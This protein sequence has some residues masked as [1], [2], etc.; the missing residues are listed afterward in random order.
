MGVTA[1]RDVPVYRIKYACIGY[2]Q[3]FSRPGHPEKREPSNTTKKV[4]HSHWDGLQSTAVMV[5]K[6]KGDNVFEVVTLL[7]STAQSKR[8]S[9][10]CSLSK[11]LLSRW[12]CPFHVLRA[13]FRG[14][15]LTEQCRGVRLK[16]LCC[17]TFP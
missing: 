16:P 11:G 5:K 15:C 12:Q 6:A 4:G 3:A 10:G 17:D 7:E 8:G 2:S 13:R 9:I 14:Q 1:L